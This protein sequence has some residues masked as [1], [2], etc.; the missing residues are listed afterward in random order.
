MAIDYKLPSEIAD[1]YLTELKGL[2]PDVNTSQTA[3]DWWIR[4]RVVGGLF[5]GIYADQR[6]IANDAFPQRAREEAVLRGIDLY[7]ASGYIPATEAQGYASVTGDPETVVPVLTQFV[8]TPNG[9]VYQS[10][11]IITLDAATGGQ[12]TGLVPIVSVA[13]GQDQNL[14]PYAPLTIS[15][16]PP[17]LS[18]TADAASGGIADG[19]NQETLDQA[20][21]RLLKR[22][23]TP[24]SVGR[25]SD[26]EQQTQ[27]ASNS[28][29]SVSVERY[30]FGLGT[31][32][33]YI[34]SGTTDIDEAIDNNQ[35]IVVIPSDELVAEVQAY[36]E[37]NGLLTDCI[38]VFKC[39][40]IEIDVEV[41][42][43]Y[44][45][46]D[47]DTIISGQEISQGELVEREV[48]RALYKTPIGGQP[49]GASGYVL[50]S[51]IE[52]TIELKLMN[53]ELIQGSIPILLDLQ[54]EPLSLT[55]YNRSLA[56]SERPIPGTIT[57]SEF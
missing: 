21:A 28:V 27:I 39:V 14:L 22:I 46:G 12:V 41:K 2:K 57:V 33:I 3:S 7:T 19:R 35:P 51:Y 29:T 52:D 5:S 49:I 25:V 45:T 1:D 6:L 48:M 26:Y 43:S 55:G 11:E 9:N 36:L 37:E 31:V 53:T 17:G 8:Y 16:P 54:V 23:R 50:C 34:S 38:S 44:S 30:P 15:S 40:P 20:R 13:A 4:S 56:K 18:N 10:S 32:G 42:V 47:S 24:L